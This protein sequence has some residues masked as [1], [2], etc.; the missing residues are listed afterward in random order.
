M[1]LKIRIQKK[2]NKWA[3]MNEYSTYP[4]EC[5][6]LLDKDLYYV[7]TGLEY[8]PVRV[9]HGDMIDIPVV[10]MVCCD[11]LE[12][13][14][15]YILS[16]SS[17][18]TMSGGGENDLHCINM[19]QNMQNTIGSMLSEKYNVINN[20]NM[21]DIPRD[22][23]KQFDNI[24]YRTEQIKFYA[25]ILGY[26]ISVQKLLPNVSRSVLK[27]NSMIT[28][29]PHTKQPQFSQIVGIEAA[30]GTIEHTYREKYL[31]YKKKYLQLKSINHAS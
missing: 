23:L 24:E 16:S 17:T 29:S 13:A 26:D 21:Y 9:Q 10:G 1:L 8:L 2:S 27:I 31:K 4:D 30:G 3:F 28:L 25:K 14:R 5:E 18:G 11:T 15:K 12:D 19:S 7:T 6:I 22:E 20:G